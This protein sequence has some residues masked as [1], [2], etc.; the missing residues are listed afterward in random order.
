MKTD[1]KPKPTC[2]APG[3][4]RPAIAKGLCGTHYRRACR[5]EA[6]GEKP[7]LRAPVARRGAELVDVRARLLEEDAQALNR[8]AD[9]RGQTLY[10]FAGDVLAVA[11]DLIKAARLALETW[12]PAACYGVGTSARKTLEAAERVRRLFP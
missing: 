7:D 3:C 8:L 12:G 9:R 6:A 2:R 10:S 1:P 11:P 4:D 5:A